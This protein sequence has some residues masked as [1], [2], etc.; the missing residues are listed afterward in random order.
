VVQGSF[1]RN[2][3]LT[4]HSYNG[5]MSHGFCSCSITIE[6]LRQFANFKW[7]PAG[8]SFVWQFREILVVLYFRTCKPHKGLDFCFCCQRKLI[9]PSSSPILCITCLRKI[10]KGPEG[11]LEKVFLPH[12]IRFPFGT[13]G[14]DKSFIRKQLLDTGVPYFPRLPGANFYED[15][16]LSFSSL[17]CQH[18]S[19]CGCS[20]SVVG[21]SEHYLGFVFQGN[22]GRLETQYIDALVALNAFIRK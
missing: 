4:I 7:R 14:A 5:C 15:F 11:V 19:L 21:K 16:T 10:R 2:W 1:L 8:G 6:G 17:D 18:F 9:V 12:K 22:G 3:R 20:I 13:P